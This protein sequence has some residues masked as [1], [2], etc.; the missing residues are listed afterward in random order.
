MRNSKKSQKGIDKSKSNYL[1]F[2]LLNEERETSEEKKEEFGN[3]CDLS[4]DEEHPKFGIIGSLKKVNPINK[5]K[6]NLKLIPQ[7]NQQ[8][9][10]NTIQLFQNSKVSPQKQV[11]ISDI[12]KD[13]KS[14]QIYYSQRTSNINLV[15][16]SIKRSSISNSK[17]SRKKQFGK[18]NKKQQQLEPNNYKM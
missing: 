15:R 14:K 11:V 4:N 7:N 1:N 3:K 17:K 12:E 6:E 10:E 2:T 5:S 18:L 13:K 8:D 9:L 16:N